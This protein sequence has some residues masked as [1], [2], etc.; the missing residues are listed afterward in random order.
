M[1]RPGIPGARGVRLLAKAVP[2]GLD[3]RGRID[4]VGTPI[5]SPEEL[6]YVARVLRDPR[7]ETL[8][9]FWVKDGKIVAQEAVTSRMPGLTSLVESGIPVDRVYS[10]AA[11][12]AK[13]LGV[14]GYYL[15]HNHPSGRTTPSKEDIQSTGNHVMRLLYHGLEELRNEPGLSDDIARDILTVL[16]ARDTEARRPAPWGTPRSNQQVQRISNA[17]GARGTREGKALMRL[18]QHLPQFL[19]HV[20]IDHDTYA[21]IAPGDQNETGWESGQS[22]PG[23]IKVSSFVPIGQLVGTVDPL[24]APE[25]QHPILGGVVNNTDVLA[26]IGRQLQSATPGHVTVIYTSSQHEIVAA[27]E[28]PESLYTAPEAFDKHVAKNQTAFGGRFVFAYFTN[29]K[30]NAATLAHVTAG[31]L[32]D[33]VLDAGGGR[34]K[35]GPAT[36]GF[37]VS[38][39][40]VADRENALVM[41]N[42]FRVMEDASEDAEYN[43]GLRALAIQDELTSEEADEY[44][45]LRL[46]LAKRK[47]AELR[48]TYLEQQKEK[49][50]DRYKKEVER[51]R[52]EVAD[53]MADHPHWMA[54]LYFQKGQVHGQESLPAGL[55][56]PSGQPWKMSRDE[57]VTRY[58]PDILFDLRTGSGGKTRSVGK[59]RPAPYSDTGTEDLD[60]LAVIFG[61]SGAEDMVEALA[62]SERYDDAYEAR[63]KT[64]VDGEL[65]NIQDPDQLAQAALD[66]AAGPEAVDQILVDL[67][68]LNRILVR[69][70]DERRQPVSKTDLRDK[71]KAEI[72]RTRAGLILPY[73]HERTASKHGRLAFQASDRGDLATAYT[74]R[75]RQLWQLALFSQAKKGADRVK[76][77]RKLTKRLRGKNA[78]KTL[79]KAGTDY[80]LRVNELLDRYDMRD[81][82]NKA[83]KRNPL[84]IEGENLEQWAE[85]MYN[86]EGRT[87]VV[88]ER[89]ITEAARKKTWKELTLSELEGFRETLESLVHNAYTK[90]RLTADR[91]AREWKDIIG[92]LKAA[93][94]GYGPVLP[95]VNLVDPILREGGVLRKIGLIGK[96]FV[97]SNLKVEEFVRRLDKDDVRGPW[98]T[99]LFEPV[100]K[101]QGFKADLMMENAV[102]LRKAFE[103]L[104][105]AYRR[106]LF[107]ETKEIKALGQP[108]TR[109]F[110]IMVAVNTGTEGNWQRLDEGKRRSNPQWGPIAVREIL[111][112]LPRE[113]WEFVVQMWT[114]FKKLGDLTD[115]LERRDSGVPLKRVKL[116]PRKQDLPDGTTIDLPGGYFPIIYDPLESGVGE[117]Q[118][119]DDTSGKVLQYGSRVTTA[120]GRTKERVKE[121]HDPLYLNLDLMPSKILEAVHDISHRETV[122]QIDRILRD[123]DIRH[124]MLTRLGQSGREQFTSWL[125]F[126]AQGR[127]TTTQDDKRLEKFAALVRGNIVYAQLG[128]KVSIWTQNAANVFNLW[129]LGK[130]KYN[131][132]GVKRFGLPFTRQQREEMEWVHSM[133]PEMRHRFNNF[134]RDFRKEFVTLRQ[135]RDPNTRAKEHAFMMM[136]FTDRMTAYPAWI[137][138]YEQTLDGK[139]PIVGTGRF[140]PGGDKDVARMYADRRVRLTLTAAGPKDLARIMRGPE[141]FKAYTIYM[142]WFSGV[143]NRHAALKWDVKESLKNKRRAEAFHIAVVRAM[144]IA[145]MPAISSELL[146]GRGPDDDEEWYWWALRKAVF[147]PLSSMPFV[148]DLARGA[149]A[150]ITGESV[151]GR[152]MTTPIGTMLEA[153]GKAGHE[154]VGAGAATLS[155]EFELDKKALAKAATKAAGVVFGF[156]SSQTDITLGYWYDVFIEGSEDPEGVFEFIQKSAYRR[157]PANKRKKQGGVE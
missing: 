136:V 65:G 131:I 99:Y 115:E 3:A 104:P 18:R 112:Y 87:I 134:E 120:Q 17:F 47:Q 53:E 36:A 151:Y 4:L 46:E 107:K 39:R 42:A 150:A 88:D 102:E 21:N 49:A 86:E 130:T 137:G 12:R 76:S 97:D 13:R 118:L 43:A 133:S 122:R 119:T 116:T 48:Q 113:D 143:A 123:P 117:K 37:Y 24:T 146:S 14:D 33:A 60:G 7:F 105:A 29:P 94:E 152:G 52:E 156:P 27:E 92:E 106:R 6:A 153:V 78:Q 103:A 126:I 31:V 84:P 82:S 66:A 110:M 15:L 19:S 148:R 10:R 2:A 22:S 139:T 44:A 5:G 41:A 72:Q 144:A 129:D 93:I 91:D 98:N 9:V 67:R 30:M 16:G 71:A 90:V 155:D 135:K 50:E 62:A 34:R 74:E 11:R 100:S 96:S 58:G 73:V 64:R 149:E 79:G 114:V 125:E 85:R 147:Y 59:T 51:I 145:I 63:V 61:F 70:G 154:F 32:M 75:L 77:V 40:A 127:E 141:W 83:L 111:S 55:A 28:V 95:G 128:H 80:Y 1:G 109:A 108:V 138:A 132:L 57:L 56:N 20:I 8:R 54:A 81:I 124:A 69:R 68:F 89:L 26:N 25:L 45:A 38:E 140:L 121:F 142:T 157:P 101:A 23:E 35:R